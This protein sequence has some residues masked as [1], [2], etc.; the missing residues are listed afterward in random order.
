MEASQGIK[1]KDAHNYLKH[2]L[3]SKFLKSFFW[4]PFGGYFDELFF[5]TD[6]RFLTKHF[7]SKQ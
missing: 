3:V 1:I 5:D 2:I 7:G 4:A 6:Y